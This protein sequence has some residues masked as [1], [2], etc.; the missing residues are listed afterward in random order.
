M[1][2]KDDDQLVVE[3]YTSGTPTDSPERLQ[4]ISIPAESHIRILMEN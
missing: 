1:V 3:R 2:R 4:E